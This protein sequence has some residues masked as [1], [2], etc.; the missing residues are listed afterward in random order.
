MTEFELLVAKVMSNAFIAESPAIKAAKPPKRHRLA[1]KLKL[2]S[3]EQQEILLLL[4]KEK[5][6][7]LTVKG[8]MYV[9]RRSKAGY[10]IRSLHDSEPEHTVAPDFSSCSC[11]DHTFRGK[12][13]KHMAALK[14]VLNA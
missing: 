8:E 12:I 11:A 6:A 1:N 5:L 10:L 4:L 14:E 2:M 3:S 7:I 13:C 9:Y